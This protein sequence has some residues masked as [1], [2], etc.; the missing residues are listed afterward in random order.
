MNDRLP[1]AFF[2][3]LAACAA[4]YFS[5]YYPLLSGAIASHFDLHGNPNGWESKRTFFDIFAGL[6]L[7]SAA[8]V[9][10]LPR[11]IAI[12]PKRLINLPN[13]EYWLGPAQWAASMEF[14]SAWFA[15]FGCAVYA[16]IVVVFDYAVQSNLHLPAGINPGRLWYMLVF[17]AAFSLV[18]T[19]VLMG[20]FGR[21]PDK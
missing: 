13:K 14:L 3:L 5:H 19:I 18:W 17:F 1:R 4:I 11:M 8:L 9:F 6:T 20:R 21:R 12:T 16:V 10:G 15:W 2:I 7:L